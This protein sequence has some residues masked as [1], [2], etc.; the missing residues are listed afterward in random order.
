MIFDLSGKKV[1]VLLIIALLGSL[2]VGALIFQDGTSLRIGRIYLEETGAHPNISNAVYSIY[3]VHR[4]YDTL[5]ELLIF[6]TA[7]LGISIFSDLEVSPGSTSVA[8]VESHVVNASA[9][10][11]YPLIGLFGVFLAYSAHQGPG[12]G[13]AGGVISGTGVLLLAVASGA[14]HIGKRFYEK[15]MKKVEFLIL[16]T[17]VLA[18]IFGL[19]FPSEMYKNLYSLPNIIGVNILIGA[20]VFIGTWAILH[21]FVQHRGRI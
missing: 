16:L 21:F 12:G 7:V 11:L 1:Y 5:L 4:F 18:A 2:T 17:L 8:L 14:E 19:F 13:F 15:R 10:F 6:S 3:G 20:K 9:S